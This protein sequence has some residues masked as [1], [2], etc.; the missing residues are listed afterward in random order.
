VRTVMSSRQAPP[1]AAT[2]RSFHQ[3]LLNTLLANVTTGYLWFA[4][5]FWAYLETK[6]VLATAIIGGSYMLLVAAFGMVFGAIVDHMKKKAVM[7]ISSVVTLAT[8]LAGGA[9]YVAFPESVLIDW[10]GPWFWM[11]ASVIL[12]GGV[13]ENLRNI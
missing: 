13:V 5:T 6:S 9:L 3:V 1:G 8:Y 4:L 11:F 10:G 12:V 7:L 2:M